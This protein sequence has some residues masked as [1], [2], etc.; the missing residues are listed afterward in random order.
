MTTKL[1]SII[2]EM[3]A[4]MRTVPELASNTHPE[5]V[6]PLDIAQLPAVCV[7]PKRTQPNALGGSVQGREGT[8]VVIVRTAGDEPGRTAHELLH[9]AHK[10]VMNADDFL[11][12][13]VQIDLG[14]ETFRYIDSEQSMCDLQAEYEVSFDIDRDSLF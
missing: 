3:V 5:R 12:G 10:A 7:M 11:E 2:D 13:L 1:F 8:I 6:L 4:A 14:A 9:L